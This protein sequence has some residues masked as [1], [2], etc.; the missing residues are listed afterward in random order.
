M[1]LQPHLLFSCKFSISKSLF[2]L[3][4]RL[5]SN[6]QTKKPQASNTINEHKF[7]ITTTSNNNNTP[8]K[9]NHIND[10]N[11]SKCSAPTPT[12]PNPQPTPTAPPPAQPSCNVS[13]AATPPAHH[14]PVAELPRLLSSP[15]SMVTQLLLLMPPPEPTTPTLDTPHHA[16]VTPDLWLDNA[17]SGSASLLVCSSVSH[18]WVIRSRVLC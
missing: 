8:H 5:S 10:L 16:E 7:I 13:A 14:A 6:I 1:C 17:D 3:S 4:N 15:L 2:R 12:T 11:H 18:R 9:T